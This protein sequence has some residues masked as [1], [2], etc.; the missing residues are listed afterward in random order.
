M[1]TNVIIITL[2]PILVELIELNSGKIITADKVVLPVG[3]RG[4]DHASNLR[5]WSY[6]SSEIDFNLN[7]NNVTILRK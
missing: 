7:K 4:T 3:F 1:K 6:I 5:V 2:D